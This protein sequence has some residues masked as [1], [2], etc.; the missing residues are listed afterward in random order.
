LHLVAGWFT[1]RQVYDSFGAIPENRMP[2]DL[3]YSLPDTW[4]DSAQS[5]PHAA[6]G[7]VHLGDGR[8]YD[9]AIGRPLQPNTAGAPPTMPQA[10]N[11]YTAAA[12]GQPGVLQA[13]VA[14]SLPGVLGSNATANALSYGVAETLGNTYV[15]DVVTVSRLGNLRLRANERLLNRA[16]VRGAFTRVPSTGGRGISARYISSLVQEVGEDLFRVV[17]GPQAGHLIDLA[18]VRAA[19]RPGS[20]WQVR[21]GAGGPFEVTGYSISHTPVRVAFNTLLRDFAWNAGI[22]AVIETPFFVSNVLSDPYLTPRQ[23]GLQG[24][25]TI[26][27]IGG[28]A[29]IGAMVGNVP[30]A[31]AAVAFGLGYE[32]ILKPYVF[33]TLSISGGVIDRIHQTIKNRGRD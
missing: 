17:E 8:Y 2:A 6:A 16:G 24:V 18:K 31:I 19:G 5:V 29:F 7:L 27:G 22:A 23:K 21:Y 20:H 1:I 11:R 14:S 26:G 33:S 4:A 28:A 12:A 3:T 10:L 25:I 13:A 30:G 15:Y 32:Y 9:P